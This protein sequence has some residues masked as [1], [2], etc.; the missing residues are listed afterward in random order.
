MKILRTVLIAMLLSLLF[1]FAIGT[2]IRMRMERPARYIGSAFCDRPFDVGYA[3][4]S[5]FDAG[6]HEQQIG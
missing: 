1:G 2:V 4:T 5:V 3:R 6:Q